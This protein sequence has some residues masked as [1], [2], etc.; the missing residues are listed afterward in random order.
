[1]EVTHAVIH[2]KCPYFW[3]MEVTHAVIHVKCPYFW[4]MDVT[5]AGIHVN[6]PLILDDGSN[7][8]R[9][10]CEVSVNFVGLQLKSEY[11]YQQISSKPLQLFSSWYTL[12]N[13]QTRSFDKASGCILQT[14]VGN[15]PK[16]IRVNYPLV[17]P[18]ANGK[19]YRVYE[20]ISICSTSYCLYQ[21]IVNCK[22]CCLFQ[23]VANWKIIRQLCCPFPKC[24]NHERRQTFQAYI[25]QCNA[26]EEM[27]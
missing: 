9:Y 22:S 23:H 24:S 5:Y 20:F 11:L 17:V 12:T 4:T 10:S 16:V 18:A 25:V 1:M 26:M 7:T 2:V 14:Y 19:S 15:E 3:T 8:C 6:C 13:R 27:H 21:S